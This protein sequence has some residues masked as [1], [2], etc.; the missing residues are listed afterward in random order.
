MTKQEILYRYATATK[1]KQDA[2][3]RTARAH[4]ERRK[5]KVTRQALAIWRANPNSRSKL[6]RHYL[7][8]YKVAFESI[9]T[10]TN[11]TQHDE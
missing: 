5:I 6:N 2:M 1:A 4:L 10:N 11:N 8:A 3:T 9:F 7:E